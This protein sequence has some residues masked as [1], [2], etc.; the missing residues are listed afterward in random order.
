VKFIATPYMKLNRK[1]VHDCNKMSL[2][3]KEESGE[4]S[5]D[6]LQNFNGIFHSGITLK[7]IFFSYCLQLN[8]SIFWRSWIPWTAIFAQSYVNQSL[9]YLFI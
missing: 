4:K 3:A 2:F 1:M 8:Y 5:M 9:Q 7:Y 6:I